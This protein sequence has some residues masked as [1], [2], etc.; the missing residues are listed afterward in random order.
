MSLEAIQTS[1][2]LNEPALTGARSSGL[3]RS[4]FIFVAEIC[5]ILT[6]AAWLR[7]SGLNS[8]SMWADE[9][10]T[11]WFSQFSPR[12]QWHL[13]EW[14]NGAPLYYA[15]IHYWVSIWGLSEVSF[16][17][18]SALCSMLS[19][20]V[21]C[22]IAHKVWRNRLFVSLSLILYSLSFFQ[23]W[24]AKESRCYA[25]F[26]LLVLICI[27]VMLSCLS[28][29]SAIRLSGLT[30]A[31]TLVLY[32]HNMALFYLPGFAAFWFIYP[33]QMTLA[34]R[35]KRAAVVGAI[36]SL[37]YVPWLSILM[38]Q[39]ASVHGHFWAPKP[40]TKDLFGTL[41]TFCGIDIYVLQDLR[42]HLP[43][44]RFFGLRT[45]T[46]L[47]LIALA[48]CLAGTL[49]GSRS[50]DR[51]KGL[52]LQF[53]TLS[54]IVLVFLW[55]L[56]STSVYVDRN[57]IGAAVLMP[58]VLCAPI[59]VQFGDKRRVFQVL[60]LLLVAGAATSL[61]MHQQRKDD[62]R[63]T[64]QYLLDIPEHQRLVV[65]FQPFCQIL[66][67]YY[68]TGLFRSHPHPEI[69]GLITDFHRQPSGPG[70]LPNLQTADPEAF[71]SQ[72][73]ETHKYKEIDVALQ[74]ERLPP[75]VQAIPDFL[76]TH[77]TSVENVTFKNLGVTRCMV[78][79]N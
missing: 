50:V 15:A 8:Q 77:C 2:A 76:S 3:R 10:F 74:L 35:F 78:P 26:A 62:W 59:A 68:A 32:T 66:V 43:I 5:I 42:S 54:P 75:K 40:G 52:A 16:R 48:A 13:L 67:N 70:L 18:L 24:Y 7:W 58:L 27:Y 65:V 36:V 41:S 6:G 14:D 53:A 71:L 57:L 38:K 51:R 37:L 19:L 46:L 1:S 23:I 55:S 11:T 56:I 34:A 29:P 17:A 49:F 28:E 22:L 47:V 79:Q 20:F 39:A 25:L 9:G 30:I 21:F 44:S 72:A 61:L 45:W 4:Q 60:V 64:T 69:T 63:G 31:F 33:S 73:M 12:V